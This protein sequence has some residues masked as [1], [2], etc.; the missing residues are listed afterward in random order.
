M[1]EKERSRR[2]IPPLASWENVYVLFICKEM[3]LEIYSCY[4]YAQKSVIIGARV[5]GVVLNSLAFFTD[6][7]G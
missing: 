1:K 7:Q 6:N 3:E 2:Q 4:R 5:F